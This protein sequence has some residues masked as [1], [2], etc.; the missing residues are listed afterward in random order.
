MEDAAEVHGALYKG[1]KAGNIDDVGCFSFYAKKIITTGEGGM[2]VTDDRRIS[3]KA[4][5]YRDLCCKPVNYICD[6]IDEI[7]KEGANYERI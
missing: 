4:Q 1:K 3:E 6:A 2:I 7:V 5:V